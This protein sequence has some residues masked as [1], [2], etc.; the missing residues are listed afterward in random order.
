MGDK[1]KPNAKQGGMKKASVAKPRN[2]G[3]PDQR[4]PKASTNNTKPTKA[5][6]SGTKGRSGGAKPPSK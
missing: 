5:P 1:P 6:G 2:G 3:T 4:D